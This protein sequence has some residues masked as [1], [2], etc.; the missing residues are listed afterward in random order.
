MMVTKAM[1]INWWQNASE[2]IQD[3]K[4]A[5]Y[6]QLRKNNSPEYR[7]KNLKI[8]QNINTSQVWEFKFFS[9]FFYFLNFS[10]LH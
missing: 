1:K 3:T 7:K 10:L 9:Y 2:E 5:V 8:H 6:S 4:Y